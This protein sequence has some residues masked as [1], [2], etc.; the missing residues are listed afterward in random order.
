MHEPSAAASDRGSLRLL[1]GWSLQVDGDDVALGLREQ[2]LVALLALTERTARSQIAGLLWPDS[3]DERALA[4]LRRA[5]LQTQKGRP[6]L[7]RVDRATVRLDPS[8]RVDVD[9]VRRAAAAAQQPL[10]EP[11]AR[12]LLR[13]LRGDEL[14]PGW[15]EDWAVDERER[16]DRARV[17]ALERIARHCLDAGLREL[18]IEASRAASDI[19]PLLES[20][21]EVSIRA[22]VARGDLGGALREL[23]RYGGVMREELGVEPSARIA[24]LLEA[25]LPAADAPVAIP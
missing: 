22:H 4:S 25:P 1:G 5:V 15:Y 24:A 13:G 3:T 18:A 17:D 7:L 20:P 8:V 23:H 14:L 16:V 11:A 10:T 9:D 12:D 6:G 19:E 2:R 21:R